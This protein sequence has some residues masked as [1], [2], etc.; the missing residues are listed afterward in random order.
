MRIRTS[1]NVRELEAYMQQFPASA[2]RDA[3]R[4][5]VIVLQAPKADENGWTTLHYAAA[6]NLPDLVRHLA[7]QGGRVNATLRDDGIA[8]GGDLGRTLQDLGVWQRFSDWTRDGETPLHV[9]ATV[10]A[11]D[12]AAELVAM[13]ADVDRGTKFDWRPLHYAA[14]AD[15]AN[16]IE[17]L[18]T[19]GA[20][21][22]SRTD[23]VNRPGRTPLE[24]AEASGN[25]RAASVLRALRARR[26]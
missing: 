1:V 26:R 23:E 25:P 14:W 5:R 22:D 15:A 24:I 13:G 11:R 8:L 17:L 10:G 18:V 21:I 9:A 12:A 7:G 16:V 2:Y 4:K 3:A 19:N 20:D 6:L